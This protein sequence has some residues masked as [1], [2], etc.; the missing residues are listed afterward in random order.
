MKSIVAKASVVLSI[1]FIVISI[2]GISSVNCLNGMIPI[3]GTIIN[4]KD[5]M[6]GLKYGDIRSLPYKLVP[7]F[8]IA[9]ILIVLSSV[10]KFTKTN[11]E[12]SIINIIMSLVPAVFVFVTHNYIWF[13]ILINIYLLSFICI[14]FNI[15]NKVDIVINIIT[16]IINILNF[17]QI[18]KHL[19]LEFAPSNVIVFEESLIIMSVNTLKIF[20]LWLIPYTILLIKEIVTTY[21]TSRTVN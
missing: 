17:I 12:K 7:L 21:K 18:I 8:Y 15:K 3:N 11:K 19:N 9:L 6:Y 4:S 13:L 5:I 14:D 1:I 20:S 10:I 2:C 16:I